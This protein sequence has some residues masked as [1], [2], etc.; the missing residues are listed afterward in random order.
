MR[1]TFGVVDGEP[2][3]VVNRPRPLTL[4]V[5]DAR[6]LDE[7]KVRNLVAA[8]AARPFD[9]S[10]GPLL[11]AR[12]LRLGDGEHL[13]LLT[14]HH[15]ISDG[16]STG[17]L[18]REA[19]ALYRAFAAG[20]PSPLA[21]LPV[22]YADYAAWQRRWL[23]GDVLDAQLSYWRERLADPPPVLELPTDRPRPAQPSNRSAGEP[24]T[25][26]ATLARALKELSR[27]ESVTLYMVLLAAFKALLHRYTGATD[28][29]V[30]TP[31]AGRTRTELEEL[32]GFFVNTLVMRTSLAGDVT[33]RELLARVRET[34][35]GAYLHQDVPFERLIEELRPARSL[36]HTPFF[37][38]MFVLHNDVRDELDMP[39]LHTRTGGGASATAKFDLTLT[40]QEEADG[41]LSA[42][43]NYNADLFDQSTVRRMAAHYERLL[44]SRPPTPGRVSPPCRY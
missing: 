3:Q 12:L 34:A 1:T 10:N 37:Q 31:I 21:E 22:Q 41:S 6:A 8:E 16:W 25:I 39:G 26:P 11:R 42:H 36:N 4:A 5:C 33:F 13:L 35:L 14:A 15:I 40:L 27:A 29:S 9:L 20:L 18:I 7:A 19:S 23:Q 17:V 38:T 28:I 44:R 2:V 30:G 32:I 43:L 24:F